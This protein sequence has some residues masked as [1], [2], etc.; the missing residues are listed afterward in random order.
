MS[1]SRRKSDSFIEFSSKGSLS[2]GG[3]QLSTEQE[4]YLQKLKLLSLQ[5]GIGTNVS[6]TLVEAVTGE[7][8]L[9]RVASNMSRAASAC[10]TPI[11]GVSGSL[12]DYSPIWSPQQSCGD[13]L[14]EQSKLQLGEH[15]IE[16]LAHEGFIPPRRRSSTQLDVAQPGRTRAEKNELLTAHPLAPE[17]SAHSSTTESAHSASPKLTTPGDLGWRRKKTT[18]VARV[19]QPTQRGSELEKKAIRPVKPN[20]AVVKVQVVLSNFGKRLVTGRYARQ[21]DRNCY[22]PARTNAW[23][24]TSNTPISHCISPSIP[25]Y[26]TFSDL[27]RPHTR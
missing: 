4:L 14:A 19:D 9:S 6:S 7:R 17:H 13:Q 3:S 25:V 15:H 21:E 1:R 10:A 5:A 26:E 24:P 11:K 12:P 27:M 22:Y 20:G 18:A 23:S 2:G 8:P 16:G